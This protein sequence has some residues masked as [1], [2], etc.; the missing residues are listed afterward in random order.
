MV[1]G[2][3]ISLYANQSISS[4]STPK[5]SNATPEASQQDTMNKLTPI[6]F[7]GMFLFFPLP[8]GVMLYMLIANIFQTLQAFIV[9][10]E[11]LPENL[12]KLVAV[13]A[14]SAPAAKSN[15]KADGKETASGKPESGKTQSDAKT[16]S[17]TVVDDK[18]KDSNTPTK[19]ALPFEPNSSKKKKKGS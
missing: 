4:G 13:S 6:I 8:S 18:D 2:F 12:Q 19:S 11:P 15:P 3:G 16:K 5:P 14:N 10:K 9:A 7:S 1:L 17:A